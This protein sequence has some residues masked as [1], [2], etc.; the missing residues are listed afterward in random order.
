MVRLGKELQE[1]GS[2]D[3]YPGTW[4]IRI[5]H[6]DGYDRLR[7]DVTDYIQI[8]P[9]QSYILNIAWEKAP[10]GGKQLAFTL[11]EAGSP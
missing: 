7:S 3:I 5:R 11:R 8:Q 10:F 1:R 9:G 4:G 2:I 6:T